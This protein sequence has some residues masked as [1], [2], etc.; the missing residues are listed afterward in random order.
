MLP[1]YETRLRK[2]VRVDTPSAVE[3]RAQREANAT[4]WTE[5]RQRRG[6]VGN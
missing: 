2:D 5:V 1:G 3:P 6:R 4:R